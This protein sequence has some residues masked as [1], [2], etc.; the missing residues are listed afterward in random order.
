MLDPRISV[1][2]KNEST[3]LLIDY[4]ANAD[5]TGQFYKCLP[6]RTLTFKNKNCHGGKISKKRITVMFAVNKDSSRKHK[7]K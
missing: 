7:P 1:D 6:D 5:E 3:S 2:W 4:E